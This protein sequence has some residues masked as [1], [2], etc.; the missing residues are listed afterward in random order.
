MIPGISLWRPCDIVETAVAW[1][2]AIENTNGPTILA[3]SRQSLPQQQRDQKT[4][5]NIARG[6]YIILDCEATPKAIIIA[7]G[8]EVDIAIKAA[9]NIKQPIRV[10]SMP[11]TDVFDQQDEAYKESVLPKKVTARLA[12]EAGRPDGWYKYA[13]QVLGITRFGESAPAKELFAEFG[14]TEQNVTR[15]IEN[16]I[17]M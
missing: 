14:F 11:A 13:G 4:L 6:G 5:A 9:K 1:Q 15:I 3:L 10:V 17:K 16:L 2:Y 12:I 8:S 7:T